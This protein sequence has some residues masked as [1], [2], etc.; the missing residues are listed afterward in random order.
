[1]MDGTWLPYAIS[2]VVDK[3]GCLLDGTKLSEAIFRIDDAVGDN[4]ARYSI[5]CVHPAILHQALDKNPDVEGRIISFCGNTS[6]L[7]PEELDGLEDLDTQEPAAFA[8]VNKKLLEAHDIPIVGACCGSG[9][10]HIREIA[11]AL[12]N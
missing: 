7:S 5:N 11:R 8:L 3:S 2:F 9:P 6:D 12:I 4:S 1:M 10:E